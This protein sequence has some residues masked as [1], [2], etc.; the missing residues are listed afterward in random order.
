M[1]VYKYKRVTTP[2]PD[3]T[4]LYFRNSETNAAVELAELD[5]WYYVHVPPDATMPDQAQ[6]IEWQEVVLT[7]EQKASIRS[8]S[9]PCQL[10]ADEMQARIRAVYAIEDEQYYSRIASS[11]ALGVYTLKPGELEKITAY[12]QHVEDARQWA[13]NERGKIGL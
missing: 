5:G 11:S 12:N 3:G 1:A 10:I 2:G 6:E 4:T 7:D 8:I 9:R 13:R